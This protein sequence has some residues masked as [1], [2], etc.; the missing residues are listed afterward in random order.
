M[1]PEVM[2]AG[3]YDASA[4]FLSG[5]QISQQKS[6]GNRLAPQPTA[7]SGLGISIESLLESVVYLHQSVGELEVVLENA[8]LLT[9]APAM[10]GST[11]PAPSVRDQRV[12]TSEMVRSATDSVRAATNH[13]HTLRDR[14][15]A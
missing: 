3:D 7:P 2:N 11:V 9:P 1:I 8:G 15:D 12:R 10:S 13:I 4:R 6:L 14:I 5:T